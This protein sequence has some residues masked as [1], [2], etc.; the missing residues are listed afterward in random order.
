MVSIS[1]KSPLETL[2]ILHTTKSGSVVTTLIS[3]ETRTVIK[4]SKKSSDYLSK[5]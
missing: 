2:L 4:R 1:R 3:Q 5:T